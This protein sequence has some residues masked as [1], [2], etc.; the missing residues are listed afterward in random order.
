MRIAAFQSNK[1]INPYIYDYNWK[2]NRLDKKRQSRDV[3][4][5]PRLITQL[6]LV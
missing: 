4:Y 2:P 1:T 5:L 3:L 6:Q